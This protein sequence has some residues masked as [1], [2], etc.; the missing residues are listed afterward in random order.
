MVNEIHAIGKL[1]ELPD[2][3]QETKQQIN[4]TIRLLLSKYT[5]QPEQLNSAQID[6]FRTI[7][8]AEQVAK[9]LLGAN[10]LNEWVNGPEKT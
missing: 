10:T 4:A 8:N 5:N 3:E 7:Q 2:L 9:E 1:L 6:A